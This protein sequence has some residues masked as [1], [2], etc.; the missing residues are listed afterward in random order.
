M[1]M[2]IASGKFGAGVIRSFVRECLIGKVCPK[3]GKQVLESER[4]KSL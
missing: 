4:A 3:N 1:D 2:I